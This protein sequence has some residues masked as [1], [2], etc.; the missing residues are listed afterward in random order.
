MSR[1]GRLTSGLN[2][3]CTKQSLGIRVEPAQLRDDL[4]QRLS[5]LFEG[6][7]RT[8]LGR[9]AFGRGIFFSHFLASILGCKLLMVGQAGPGVTTGRAEVAP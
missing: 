4:A 3:L 5:D 1:M 9:P 6:V 7:S 8:L 2:P